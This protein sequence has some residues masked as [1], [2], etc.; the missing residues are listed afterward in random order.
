MVG[1]VVSGHVSCSLEAPSGRAGQRLCW[2][3][4]QRHAYNGAES[5]RDVG[6]NAA[7]SDGGVC[8]SERV[9]RLG[10]GS[11]QVSVYSWSFHRGAS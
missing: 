2:Q 5:L 1:T 3:R 7:S 11:V 8:Q 4:R 10:A 9:C 6:F